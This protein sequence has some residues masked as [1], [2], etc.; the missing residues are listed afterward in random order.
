MIKKLIPTIVPF[1]LFIVALHSLL[2][3]YEVVMPE[4]ISLSENET[5][6]SANEMRPKVEIRKGIWF[7]IDYLSFLADELTK[8]DVPIDTVPEESIDKI[9]RILI[10]QRILFFIICFYMALCFSAFVSYLF[11]AWFYLSLNRIML[12]LGIFWSLQQTLIHIRIIPDEKIT[13]ILGLI[14]FL[15]TFLLTIF[16]IIRVEKSKSEHSNFE[17]LR[18]SSSLEEEGRAPE[19]NASGSYLK[20]FFH[21]MI[22]IAVGFLI[23][24]FV[25]I[26]LF[27]L[28]KH[29][30]TEFTV[31]IFS[32]LALL[33]GFYIYNYGKVGGEK[34]LTKLQNTLVSM[35]YLQFRFLRNGFLG[36]FATILIVF[37]VTFLFSILILNIDMIQANTGLFQ[38]GT[39]F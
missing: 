23:G 15:G 1:L 13:G 2:I 32:L 17:A 36:I 25:Y 34:T 4:P 3:D 30:V 24:N 18:H 21:F 10:G 35:A 5:I 28:Q 9:K 19:Q 38:K 31:F 7:R 6:D 8:E 26:P 22:I 29:Y 20:L 27:L 11:K 37:F 12:W 33:S 14:F 39:E 16:A